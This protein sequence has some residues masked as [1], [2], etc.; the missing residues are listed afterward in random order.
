MTLAAATARVDQ[1]DELAP[2]LAK[3]LT[4]TREAKDSLLY[5]ER[6]AYS[7]RAGVVPVERRA[8]PGGAGPGAAAARK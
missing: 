7:G 4:L 1:L 2:G 5:V 8:G 3:E 6:K